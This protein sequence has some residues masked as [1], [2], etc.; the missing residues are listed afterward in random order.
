MD[1]KDLHTCT[2]EQLYGPILGQ[3]VKQDENIRIIH[4][5]DKKGI[6][7]TLGVVRFLNIKSEEIKVAHDKILSG[8]LMGKTLYESNIEFDKEFI[9]SFEVK[10]PEWLK[11]DFNTS[12]ASSLVFYSKIFIGSDSETDGKFLYSEIIEVVPPELRKL[13]DNKIKPLSDLEENL[14]YLCNASGLTTI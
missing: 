6:S 9:G 10:L 3:L 12:K 11:T 14:L 1:Y 2:L 7:R 8:A 13:M 5:L 4:L